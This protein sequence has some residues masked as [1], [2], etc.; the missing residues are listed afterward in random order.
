[1]LQVVVLD[2]NTQETVTFYC[3]RWL[4]KTEDDGAISRDLVP[5]T[6]DCKLWPTAVVKE[7]IQ[8]SDGTAAC[9]VHH[10]V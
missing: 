4:C 5:H 3:R 10:D 2:H 1:M 7:T 9:D 8:C 6:G